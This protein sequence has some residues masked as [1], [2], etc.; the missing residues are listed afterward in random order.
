MRRSMI[1]MALFLFQLSYSQEKDSTVL[2]ESKTKC[3]QLVKEYCSSVDMAGGSF[4]DVRH[5]RC[6]AL[7]TSVGAG[8]ITTSLD[9]VRTGEVLAIAVYGLVDPSGVKR[10]SWGVIGKKRTTYEKAMEYINKMTKE[11]SDVEPAKE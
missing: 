3:M 6:F 11:P 2:L 5:N 4:Y 1:V 9:D 8:F 10:S 7:C